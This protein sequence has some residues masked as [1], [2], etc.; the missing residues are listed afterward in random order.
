[1]KN[2][3]VTKQVAM[4]DSKATGDNIR[5]ARL[6]LRIPQGEFAKRMGINPTHLCNL[7]GGNRSWSDRLVDKASRVIQREVAALDKRIP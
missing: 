3:L 6:K 2:L 5:K 4:I 7:E 1:M